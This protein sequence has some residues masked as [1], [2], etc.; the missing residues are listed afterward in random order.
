[1]PTG[2]DLKRL[3]RVRMKKTGE[4]Y[5]AARAQLLTKKPAVTQA[6]FA[7]LAGMSDASVKEATGCTWARWVKALDKAG[8]A[9]KPHREIAKLVAFYG[10]PSW[11]TQMVTVGY[12]RIRGLRDRGQQRGGGYRTTRSRTFDVPLATL[13]GAFSN[14]RT[15][16]RWLDA[17]TTVKSSTQNKRMRLAWGDG[18]FAIAG[19][20]AKGPARSMV[21]VA[22]D[23]LPGRGAAEARKHAWGDAFQRLADLVGS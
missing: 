11:W 19:F 1:M 13:Y 3:V 15:R 23:K 6:D 2:K 4:S 5:T 21:A 17:D 16:K 8:A 18:T 9:E 7:K 12:E 20:Y 14:D 22:H 10:T